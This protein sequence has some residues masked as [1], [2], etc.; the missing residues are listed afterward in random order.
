M[1]PQNTPSLLH[2]LTKKKWEPNISIFLLFLTNVHCKY[3][4]CRLIIAHC[5]KVCRIHH[6]ESVTSQYS[7]WRVWFWQKHVPEHSQLPMF[8]IELMFLTYIKETTIMVTIYQVTFWKWAEISFNKTP[9]FTML[10]ISGLTKPSSWY[11]IGV[12]WANITQIEIHAI[13]LGLCLQ[14]D[15]N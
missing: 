13:A 6:L 2:L 7:I 14:K 8:T 3:Q 15:M 4:P 5:A 12:H 9:S 10:V 11:K 1:P